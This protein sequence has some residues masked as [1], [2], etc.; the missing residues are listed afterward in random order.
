[1]LL[2][3]NDFP[4]HIS[5]NSQDYVIEVY[6]GLDSRAQLSRFEPVPVKDKDGNIVN[7][8][9]L[10]NDINNHVPDLDENG[11]LKTY[12]VFKLNDDYPK[13]EL[14]YIFSLRCSSMSFEEDDFNTVIPAI[15]LVY[16]AKDKMFAERHPEA[17]KL[18]VTIFD[19]VILKIV[20]NITATVGCNVLYLFAINDEK[21][22][23]Y[24]KK[25][26]LFDD[27][28]DEELEALVVSRLKTN[29]NKGCKFLY[30]Y[31]Y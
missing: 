22:I 9:G 3:I 20:E 7:L 13:K 15:E 31:V 12:L 17:K 4:Y 18:G 27:Y 6:K 23:S 21:L 8:G 29:D 10:K 5:I 16:F 26:L 11:F 30:Q 25:Q 2:T 1:M 24:Y 19:N 28:E 14:A